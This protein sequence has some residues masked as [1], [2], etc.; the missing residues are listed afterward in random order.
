MLK[1]VPSKLDDDS[2]DKDICCW[3]STCIGVKISSESADGILYFMK[4]GNCK[5]FSAL[6]RRVTSFSSSDLKK[7]LAS[8]FKSDGRLYV[9]RNVA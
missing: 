4:N 6:G 5:H 8:S 2:F 3:S 7:Y 9:N 1:T